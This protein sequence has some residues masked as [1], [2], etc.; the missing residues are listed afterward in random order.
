LLGA[1]EYRSVLLRLVTHGEKQV[2]RGVTLK[3]I[4]R[5]KKGKNKLDSLRGSI[6][7]ET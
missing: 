6:P 2:E 1:G 7:I 4:R 3:C 5:G